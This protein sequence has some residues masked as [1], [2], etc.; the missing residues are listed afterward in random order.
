MPS[1]KEIPCTEAAAVTMQPRCGTGSDKSGRLYFYRPITRYGNYF[2]PLSPSLSLHLAHLCCHCFSLSLSLSPCLSADACSSYPLSLSIFVPQ[3]SPQP[4][5]LLSLIAGSEIIQQ[6]K[7]E[8]VQELFFI[9]HLFNFI[10]P[11]C[12]LIYIFPPCRS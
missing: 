9:F 7:G 1:H 5:Y 2:Y 3:A 4:A 12:V 11:L 8:T 10:L 6:P